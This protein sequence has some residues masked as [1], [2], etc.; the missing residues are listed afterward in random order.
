M[1]LSC[2]TKH[3]TEIVTKHLKFMLPDGLPSDRKC[4]NNV[5]FIVWNNTHISKYILEH[6]WTKIHI[7]PILGL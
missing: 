3:Q 1:V 6:Y 5:L 4:L 7:W 2:S